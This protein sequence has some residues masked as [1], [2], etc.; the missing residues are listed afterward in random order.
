MVHFDCGA[1]GGLAGGFKGNTQAEAAHHEQELAHLRQAI[2]GIAVQGYFVDF[3]G[4]WDA[5]PA[6]SETLHS[7][8]VA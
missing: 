2:P 7:E 5:E 8:S 4:I 1:Y 3:D 6:N